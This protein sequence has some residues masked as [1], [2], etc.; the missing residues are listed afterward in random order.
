MVTPGAIRSAL[1]AK[2]LPDGAHRIVYDQ[3]S[4]HVCSTPTEIGEVRLDDLAEKVFSRLRSEGETLHQTIY[5]LYAGLDN[6]AEIRR[7][8]PSQDRFEDDEKGIARTYIQ[9]VD[10]RVS[11]Q[12][13][14]LDRQ[15]RLLGLKERARSEDDAVAAA[16]GLELWGLGI[17]LIFAVS[18]TAD[19]TTATA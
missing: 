5:R 4:V 9:A 16:L 11:P 2:S 1:A 19:A 17:Q 10:E 7:G 12:I 15:R 6:R 14:R 3:N 8:P 13:A 18:E